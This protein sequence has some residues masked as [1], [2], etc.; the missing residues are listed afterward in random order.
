MSK[1]Y[2][3]T[4]FSRYREARAAIDQIDGAGARVRRGLDAYREGLWA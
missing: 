1:F 3:G 2:L 4:T